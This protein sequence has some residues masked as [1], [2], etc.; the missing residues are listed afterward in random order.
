MQ[1]GDRKSHWNK[2][3]GRLQVPAM[4]LWL[5]PEINREGIAD[6]WTL[7][8]SPPPLTPCTLACPPKAYEHTTLWFLPVPSSNE[9]QGTNY[10]LQVTGN[11]WPL[12]QEL[13][14]ATST[15]FCEPTA[16]IFRGYK[17]IYWGLKPSF[18]M[19][20]ASKG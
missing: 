8:D 20:L 10:V 1:Q 13:N 17:P 9:L 19:V 6:C 14:M 18:F 12:R 4:Q 11:T 15:Q 16:F 3:Q 5:P 2:A 7:M